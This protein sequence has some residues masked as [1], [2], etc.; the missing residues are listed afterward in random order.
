MDVRGITKDMIPVQGRS[1]IAI[2]ISGYASG[3]YI[4]LINSKESMYNKVFIKK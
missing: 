4:L 3:A 2:D 1:E